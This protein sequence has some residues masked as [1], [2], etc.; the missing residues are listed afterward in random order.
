MKL[1]LSDFGDEM[2]DEYISD[3]LALTGTRRVPRPTQPTEVV[4]EPVPEPADLEPQTEPFAASLELQEQ[5]RAIVLDERNADAGLLAQVA[6]QLA[7]SESAVEPLPRTRAPRSTADLDDEVT[8]I[9]QRPDS[10]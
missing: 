4:R 1:D 5:A 2:I 10:K 9:V 6:Q 8:N 3:A 7:Y